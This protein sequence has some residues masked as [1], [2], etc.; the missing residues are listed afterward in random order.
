MF[1]SLVNA[2]QLVQPVTGELDPEDANISIKETD[3]KEDSS[4]DK[5]KVR[6]WI[7]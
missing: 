7:F 2:F 4:N 1:S 5:T 6:S 3:S